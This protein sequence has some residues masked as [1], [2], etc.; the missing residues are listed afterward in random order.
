MLELLDN[1]N[2]LKFKTYM[3]TGGGIIF[4]REV[5]RQIYK[6]PSD[7]IIGS[8][9]KKSLMEVSNKIVVTREAEVENYNDTKMKVFNIVDRIGKTPVFV[10]GNSHGDFQMA[11]YTS[12]NSKYKSFIGFVDHDDA[13]R[14]FDYRISDHGKPD[15]NVYKTSEKYDFTILS[16]KRDFKTVYP[17]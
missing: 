9:F 1:L 11:R 17:K 3:V 15:E 6:L 10:F 8:S 12:L 7:R 14:E 2:K 16:I 4:A 13:K 5:N